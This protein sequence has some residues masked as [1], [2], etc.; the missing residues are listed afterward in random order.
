MESQPSPRNIKILKS[1]DG[2]V[3]AAKS[4][5]IQEEKEREEADRSKDIPYHSGAAL[6][7]EALNSVLKTPA[8]AKY[9]KRVEEG[10]D[11]E[12]ESQ[13]QCLDVYKRLLAKTTKIPAVKASVSLFQDQST[14]S[15][16][17]LDILEAATSSSGVESF[18]P[19]TAVQTPI[20]S[21]LRESLTFPKVEL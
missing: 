1:G 11:I 21:I 7:L 8:K 6:A 3:I 19:K 13:S 18:N 4:I 16:T 20:F 17:G 2:Y 5:E 12:G 14:S 10:F 9:N 15:M